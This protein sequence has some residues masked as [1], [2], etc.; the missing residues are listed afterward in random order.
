MNTTGFVSSKRL[1]VGE[2]EIRAN[3]QNRRSPS[4]VV[5]QSTNAD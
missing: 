1:D 4:V 2:E 3:D 5:S